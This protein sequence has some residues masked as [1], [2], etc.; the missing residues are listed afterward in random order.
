MV[1]SQILKIKKK[2]KRRKRKR[3]SNGLNLIE[4]LVIRL[5]IVMEYTIMNISALA[6]VW[7][8]LCKLD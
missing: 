4:I 6:F 7:C 8:V 2:K 3:K 5:N 1:F